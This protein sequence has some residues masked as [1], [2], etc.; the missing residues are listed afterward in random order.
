MKIL[1]VGANGQLG[2]ELQRTVP[3]G[4]E[5]AAADMPEIDITKPESIAAVMDKECPA[6]VINCAAY[7]NVDGAESDRDAA[8]AINGDGAGNLARAASMSGAR[9]VH[10]STDFIFS[11]ESGRP[12]RPGD[13]PA[14]QSVYGSTKLAGEKA[15]AEVLGEETLII[16]TAWLYSSHGKNFVHTMIRLMGEKPA[17]TVIED[18]IGTPCWAM[19]L[20][21]A[22]WAAVEKNLSGIYHWTDAGAASWY[23]FAV[24]I[25]EE[26][27]AAGLLEKSIP[28]KPIPTEAYPTPA[29]R[30]A[31]SV[32]D[33][34]STWEATGLTPR[35]WREQ[36]RRM[37]GEIGR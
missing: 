34:T 32:L 31:Y 20:A 35:H 6:W 17:L 3:E 10:I 11:G 2:W 12:Y 1:I 30:P 5:I 29:R 27:L 8:H 16:R 23:D 36:L 21:Q 37:I 9:L 26:A 24:A 13:A 14:P 18:Q 28:V 22:V 19:G 33:K 4:V 7:T 15:V 25:Q